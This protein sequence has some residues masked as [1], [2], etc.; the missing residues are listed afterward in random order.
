MSPLSAGPLE[1]PEQ[2]RA[3][4]YRVFIHGTAPTPRTSPSKASATSTAADKAGTDAKPSP[5]HTDIAAAARQRCIARGGALQSATAGRRARVKLEVREAGEGEGV[6]DSSSSQNSL[7]DQVRNASGAVD[8]SAAGLR[9]AGTM[10]PGADA[11]LQRSCAVHHVNGG[12]YYVDYTPQVAGTSTLAIEL[13][14]G[15]VGSQLALG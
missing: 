12:F 2:L 14:A 7:L 5:F 1:V 11:S 3:S 6:I 10:T 8:D 13:V 4:P 15:N 9:F